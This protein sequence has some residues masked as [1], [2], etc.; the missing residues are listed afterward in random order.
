M[1][2]IALEEHFAFP[3][4]LDGPGRD[5]KVRAQQYG[6][7]AAKLLE[8]L[9]DLGEKRIAEM[10]AA[11]QRLNAERPLYFRFQKPHRVAK[12]VHSVHSIFD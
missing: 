3:R 1:R 4:F 12:L 10:D 8:Q 9:C 2:T 7:R 11:S 5:L 6:G